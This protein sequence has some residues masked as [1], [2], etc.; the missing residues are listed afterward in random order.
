M[1]R[2]FPTLRAFL[3][4]GFDDDSRAL[5]NKVWFAEGPAGGEPA[6]KGYE[7]Y[8]LTDFVGFAREPFE[9]VGR[10]HRRRRHQPCDP[11]LARDLDRGQHAGPGRDA[12]VDQDHAAPFEPRRR[13]SASSCSTSRSTS[14]RSKRGCRRTASSAQAVTMRAQ[15]ARS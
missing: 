10:A 9:G 8:V 3:D 5:L 13:A 12:V 2:A 6:R 1:P 7:M 15:S 4:H 11:V 14:R